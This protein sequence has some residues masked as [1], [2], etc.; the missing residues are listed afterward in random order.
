[1]DLGQYYPVLV[2]DINSFS[3]T[4]SEYNTS[5]ILLYFLAASPCDEL[6]AF[7]NP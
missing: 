1:M 4:Q 2:F 5:F 6:F 7:V 3:H